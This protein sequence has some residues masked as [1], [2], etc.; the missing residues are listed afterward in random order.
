MCVTFLNIISFVVF[1]VVK[2]A[3][4]VTTFSLFEQIKTTVLC[5]VIG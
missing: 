4:K 5:F 3:G 2:T 1:I